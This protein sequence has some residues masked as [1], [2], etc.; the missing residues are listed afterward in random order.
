MSTDERHAKIET[1]TSKIC[2]PAGIY[3]LCH[4]LQYVLVPNESQIYCGFESQASSGRTW[5]PFSCLRS[6][7]FPPKQ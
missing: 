4:R 3:D 1:N 2:G 6:R 7:S 5:I